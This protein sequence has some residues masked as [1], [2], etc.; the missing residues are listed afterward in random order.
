MTKLPE[1]AFGEGSGLPAPEQEVRLRLVDEA[2]AERR[3]G[4]V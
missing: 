3:A 1:E 2:L 4:H